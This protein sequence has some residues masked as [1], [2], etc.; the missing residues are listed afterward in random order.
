MSDSPAIIGVD[1]GGT[2]IKLGVL[3]DE[4]LLYG[5]SFETHS[6]RPRDAIVQDIAHAVAE[7]K[8]KAASEGLVVHGLG[9]GVPATIDP[10]RGQ[11]LVMPNFAEGWLGF[12][13][14]A[15]LQQRTG[16]PTALVNDARASVLAET[17][18][19]AGRGFHHVFGA[20]L[21]TGIGGGSVLNGRLY[22]GNGALAGEFGHHIV[23]LNGPL[24]GCGSYGCLETVASAPALVASVIRPFLHGRSPVLQELT[25]GD[26]SLVNAERITDAARAGDEA[27]L[28]A[29]QRA[30]RFLGI[31]LAN[32]VTLLAPERVIIGG[33]LANAHDLI[34]PTIQEAWERHARVAGELLPSLVV[35]ELGSSAG[36]I[37]AALYARL[38]VQK[39]TKEVS[40][41]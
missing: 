6:F 32:I 13:V 35:A 31:G 12:P 15:A 2:N 19:G 38:S 28:E 8:V 10:K 4:Q 1:I 14:V 30:A 26:V 24:C 3:A 7:L 33:G 22:L 11:T 21:G 9:L 36:V 39:I 25:K 23:D 5:R 40:D 34:F 27:C 16:L 20:I 29:L 41:A 17:H 37:G 18:L